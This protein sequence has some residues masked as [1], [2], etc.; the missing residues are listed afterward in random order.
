LFFPLGLR[1]EFSRWIALV[2]VQ[3]KFQVTGKGDGGEL[4]GICFLRGALEGAVEG[5]GDREKG[6]ELELNS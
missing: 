5:I 3:L 4:L 6:V 1:P 2:A